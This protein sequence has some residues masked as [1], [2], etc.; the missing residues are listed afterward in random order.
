[1][2]KLRPKEVKW[3]S[4]N[5]DPSL[6]GSRSHIHNQYCSQ[7][8]SL[9]QWGYTAFPAPFEGEMADFPGH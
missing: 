9:S 5:L 7:Y 8:P 2:R 1:M 6:F 3:Q 4:G